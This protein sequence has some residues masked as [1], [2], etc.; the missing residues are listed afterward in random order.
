M[1]AAN[2]ACRR[3]QRGRLLAGAALAV[4]MLGCSTRSTT[5][6]ITLPSSRRSAVLAAFPLLLGTTPQGVLAIPR[7]TD[8]SVYYNNQK[9]TKV[10]IFK[11]GID[12]LER[13][14]VDDRMLTFQIGRAHV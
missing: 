3:P 2:A 5:E 1:L 7:V 9:T 13:K 10:P 4:A 11:Q 8:L 6:F 12:Y 14:G